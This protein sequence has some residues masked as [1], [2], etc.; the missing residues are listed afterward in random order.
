MSR[1][2][3]ICFVYLLTVLCI[4]CGGGGGSAGPSSQ[5]ASSSGQVSASS[6]QSQTS[7]SSSLIEGCSVSVSNEAE[8]TWPT[9]DWEQ[10]LPELNG[11]CPSKLENAL[12]YAFA[13]GNETGA[14]LIVKNGKLIAERYSEDRTANDLVTSWSVAKSFTS[15]LLGAAVDEGYLIGLDQELGDFFTEWRDTKKAEI[16]I[17]QLLTVKTGLDLLKDDNGDGIPDGDDLYNS[18]DQVGISLSRSLVGEPGSRNYLYSNSDVMLAGE[19]VKEA[20]GV[21]VSDYLDTG[22]GKKIGFT[23]EWWV[24]AQS[25]VLS[26]CCL[27][28]TPRSFA[29]F[30]LLFAR[31]GLWIADQVLSED[32][33]R[34]STQPAKFNEYGYFWWPAG[35][36]G[37]SALGVMGQMIS[38][39][40]DDDLVILRFSKYQRMG[41][42]RAVREIS[43]YH[44]TSEPELFDNQEFIG[45][46]RDAVQSGAR[47]VASSNASPEAII[48]ESQFV[49]SGSLVTVFGGSSFDADGDELTF[50]WDILNAPSGSKAVIRGLGSSATFTADKEGDYEVVLTVSDGVNEVQSK[51]I[52]IKSGASRDLLERGTA[53]GMWPNYSGSLSSEKYSPLDEINSSNLDELMIVWR[54]SSPDNAL[55]AF[56]NTAFEATPL[57]VDGVLYTSTSFSQV[58]AINASD[59]T[60]IWTYD[61]QAYK[62]ARP[63]NN[64]FLHRGV[65]YIEGR[66]GKF[67]HMPT[68]D[69]RLISLN[70]ISGEPVSQFGVLSNGVV[71]LLEGVPRLNESTM[72]LDDAHD[73]PD[74][75]DLAGVVSQIGNSSPGIICRNTLVLGSSIHDGEVLPPSP[76]G[77]VRGFDPH[78]G[79]LLWTFHTVPREGEFGVDTW[80]NESWKVN[81]NT[82][83][84]PPMSVDE[85]LGMV[86]LPTGVPTNNY[87]GGRRYGDN[88]FANSVV[89][90]DCET[91]ERVWHFQTVH[92]DIWDYDLPAAPNLVDIEVEGESIKALVQVTKQGFLFVFDRETGEPVWPIIETPVPASDVPGE[93]ASATQPI[94]SWPLPFVRQ[95]SSRDDIVDQTAVANYSFGPL[96]TPPTTNGLVITPGEGGGAN[97]GGAAFDPETKVLYVVGFGPLTH[98]VT[99]QDGGQPDFYYGLPELLFGPASASPYGGDGSKITAYNMNSG[100]ILWQV[101]G[102]SDSKTIGNSSVMISGDLLYYKNSS[103]GTL[104][105]FSKSDGELLREIPLGGRPTGSPMTYSIDGKQ[106]V[107]IALGRQDEK[108]ELVALSLP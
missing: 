56:Q 10:G 49:E 69:G 57:M 44:Q 84:W 22:L 52:S 37:F 21:S 80:I 18:E 90:L 25:S 55:S 3:E 17:E 41:D 88:L 106:F 98:V 68:G 93:L 47:S 48:S 43:N 28:S 101:A 45:L 15:A 36:N 67:I 34:H 99:L 108:M 30:G 59:G 60:S 27:D 62:Y 71:D 105:V 50:D 26:Y 70:A 79:E 83:V 97:W 107:V 103:L 102:S 86:Y 2:L 64:G 38:V 1:L 66:P 58:A 72:Q 76:P 54:W 6:T 16:T 31:N 14:V 61:P 39:F 63:P 73:Q 53:D 94:P 29:R 5:G 13:E 78:S 77:D 40:P 24:D 82:N 51:Q 4:S 85:T 19:L 35:N 12:N 96:Y 46:V 81:G 32:W 87:Y 91:G 8:L 95:G 9:L 89:A 23:G 20:T 7:S 75:P 74:V 100:E 33:V 92:H 65:S 11:F 104:N 42:G